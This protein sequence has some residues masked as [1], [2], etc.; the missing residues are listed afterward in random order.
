VRLLDG[1]NPG[2]VCCMLVI[3]AL[4]RSGRKWG[5]PEVADRSC[6]AFFAWLIA[7]DLHAQLLRS[8]ERC[9]AFRG[10]RDLSRAPGVHG[11][12]RL[13]PQA[14]SG[15][16]GDGEVSAELPSS[17]ACRPGVRRQ[18]L[19]ADA[20]GWCLDLPPPF[21][22]ESAPRPQSPRAIKKSALAGFAPGTQCLA[23][24]A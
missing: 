23:A 15:D 12:I 2:S 5:N 21:E 17:D 22:N 18:P 3:V 1:F 24:L 13:K 19:D 8:R 4:L 9:E 14:D 16:T 10:T 20:I 6:F 7:T 11:S